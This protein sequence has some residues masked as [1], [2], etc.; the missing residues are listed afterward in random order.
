[1]GPD[2][3]VVSMRTFDGDCIGSADAIEIALDYIYT[4]MTSNLTAGKV[5]INLSQGTLTNYTPFSSDYITKVVQ[6]GALVFVAAGN[7]GSDACE[8]PADH[9]GVYAVTAVDQNGNFLGVSNRCTWN[10][11]NYTLKASGC[12]TSDAT[13]SV[14]A[15]NTLNGSNMTVIVPPYF[16]P[17]L[18]SWTSPWWPVLI[19]AFTIV[20]LIILGLVALIL[21]MIFAPKTRRTICCGPCVREVVF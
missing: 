1:M 5:I 19:T 18:C 20:G 12:F 10:N 2:T 17:G 15:Y 11:P 13:A 16:D 4:N 14:S 9:P 6:A 21:F 7:D 3:T 8:W